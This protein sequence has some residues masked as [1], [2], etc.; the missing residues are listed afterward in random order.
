[1]QINIKNQNKK[2]SNNKNNKIKYYII[3][4]D[5]LIICRYKKN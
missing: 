1:M 5:N 2:K 4:P 3:I